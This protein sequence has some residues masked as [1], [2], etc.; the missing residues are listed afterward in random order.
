[1]AQMEQG[2]LTLRGQG[3]AQQSGRQKLLLRILGSLRNSGVAQESLDDLEELVSKLEEELSAER[4][5]KDKLKK[6]IQV[7]EDEKCQ[8]EVAVSHFALLEPAAAH[9]SSGS[10]SAAHGSVLLRISV[11]MVIVFS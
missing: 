1:M 3:W 6:T 9:S 8:L 4:L 10:T 11:H 5:S 2:V 7:L